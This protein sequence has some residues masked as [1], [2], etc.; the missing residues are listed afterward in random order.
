MF[1]NYTNYKKTQFKR[2]ST[3]HYSKLERREKIERLK[4]E[5]DSIV[6]EGQWDFDDIFQDH[7]YCNTSES[8]FFGCVV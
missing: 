1:R 3:E 6:E 8:T 4:T 7:N 2:N 5:M